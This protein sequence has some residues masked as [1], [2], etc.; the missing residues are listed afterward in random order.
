MN[1]DYDEFLKREYELAVANGYIP[2][3][4]TRPVDDSF[5]E[6]KKWWD[7]NN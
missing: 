3:T 7:K 2:G 5:E 6:F 4:G 1:T